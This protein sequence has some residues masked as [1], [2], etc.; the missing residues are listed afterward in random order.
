M[1]TGIKEDHGNMSWDIKDHGKNL[2][3]KTTKSEDQKHSYDN[4]DFS[5]IFTS[6]GIKDSGRLSDYTVAPVN[7]YITNIPGCRQKEI[8]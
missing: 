8:V 7:W 5:V 6:S 4:V 2:W 1:S 3:K